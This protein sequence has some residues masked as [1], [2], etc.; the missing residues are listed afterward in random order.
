MDNILTFLVAGHETTASLIQWTLKL[1]CEHPEYQDKVYE[2]AR[3]LLSGP[4]SRL[5]MSMKSGGVSEEKKDAVDEGLSGEDEGS[6]VWEEAMEGLVWTKAIVNESLRQHP[7]V[8]GIGRHSNVDVTLKRTTETGEESYFF[9]KHQ[10]NLICSFEGIHHNPEYWDRPN[11]FYPERWFDKNVLK[12]PYQ[13][14]PF[15]AGPRNCIGQQFARYEA[16]LFLAIF[17]LHFRVELHSSA[18]V[19]MYETVTSRPTYIVLKAYER[20][21]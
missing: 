13:F 7:P 2:E 8:T 6:S 18:D 21:E 15:S 12:N 20:E 11:D 14:I 16:I 5:G 19:S 1:L 3:E 9:K 10:F 4:V 17:F